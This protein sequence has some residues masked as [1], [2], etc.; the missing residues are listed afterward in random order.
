MNNN[1]IGEPFRDYVAKQINLRQETHGSGAIDKRSIQ[2]VTLLNSNTAWVKLA[3]G[4]DVS[5]Q[6]MRDAGLSHFG[7]GDKLAKDFILFGGVSS[8]TSVDSPLQQRTGLLGKNGIYNISG[9]SKELDFGLV[10]MPG[11]ESVDIK[12]LNRGSIKKATIKLKVYSKTQF[13]IIDILYL[14]LGYT[15]LLEWGNSVYRSNKTEN[16]EQMGYTFIEADGGFFSNNLEKES[17]LQILKRL[18][19]WRKDKSGNYDSLLARVVNFEWSFA[20]DGSYDITL[21]LISLGDIVESLKIN[22]SPGKKEFGFIDQVIQAQTSTTEEENTEEKE[23]NDPSPLRNK[24]AAHLFVQKIFFKQTQTPSGGITYS[25][26]GTSFP[27]GAFI[28]PATQPLEIELGDETITFDP[29]DTNQKKTDVVY[30]YYN[31]GEEEMPEI[32][33]DL[34]FYMRFGYLLQFIRN[35]VLPKI[36]KGNSP[37]PPLIDIDFNT[38]KNKMYYFPGQISLDPR[39]CVVNGEI[40]PNNEI[41]AFN[42]LAGWHHSDKGYAWP[43]NIYVSFATIQTALDGN[44]DNDGNLN[45]QSFLSSICDALNVSLG[46]VNNLEPIVDEDDNSIKII[47]SSYSEKLKPSQDYTLML[48]GYGDGTISPKNYSTFVRNIDLKTAITPEYASMVTVGATAGGYVKGTEATMFS[49]WNKGIVDRFAPK[50]EPGDPETAGNTSYSSNPQPKPTGGIVGGVLAAAAKFDGDE[51]LVQYIVKFFATGKLAL[52][53]K[54]DGNGETPQLDDTAIENNKSIATEFYKYAHSKIHEKYPDWSSP[55]IGFI[56]FSLGLTMD[57]LAGIK[58]YNA[59]KVDTSFLPTNYPNSLS[60]IITGVDHKLSSN[61]W[62]T[63]IQTHVIPETE[64]QDGTPTASPSQIKDTVLSLL[65]GAGIGNVQLDTTLANNNTSNGVSNAILSSPV[66]TPTGPDYKPISSDDDLWVYL[67][68]QQGVGGAAQHYRVATGKRK[69]YGIKANALKQNWPGGKVASNG[70]RKQDIDLLYATNQKKLAIGFIDVW[71]QHYKEKT[72]RALTLINSK[73]ANRTGVLYSEIK[74]TFQKY[75]IPSKGLTWDKLARFGLIENSLNTDDETA[76]TF[77]GMF[78][79][80]KTY[81]K[82]PDNITILTTSKKGQ[83]HKPT[84]TEYDLDKYVG[85]LASRIAAK[86]DEF[87]RESGYPN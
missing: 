49:K 26:N 16:L 11:I 46:G 59:I 39:V 81:G 80:N 33:L 6:R 4:V 24:I 56:P 18:E 84:Y 25:I 53:Y 36:S 65:N 8:F 19:G 48:Y 87:K 64:K 78:Q 51:A 34:G 50:L 12:C 63:T 28:K 29:A 7:W 76:T 27:I 21:S 71:R 23:T 47:D 20:Q 17:P 57:G 79:I 60:F 72:S 83:G 77:Q 41:D 74:K 31:N 1:I 58:I 35:F 44:L 22:I 10:P 37:N 66:F 30:F 73:G 32:P 70:V 42:Q 38:W 54:Y 2:D 13:D 68:W 62:E 52:G 9:D 14:R 85:P 55:T 43:M 86:L 82:N 45:L 69:S 75:E 3:S 40:G 67:S 61:D 5:E 15:V